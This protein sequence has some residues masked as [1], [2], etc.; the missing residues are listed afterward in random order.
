MKHPVPEDR[1][2]V[3]L[4]YVTLVLGVLCIWAG[5][6]AAINWK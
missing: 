1:V 3:F 4:S 6:M 2:M 5:I